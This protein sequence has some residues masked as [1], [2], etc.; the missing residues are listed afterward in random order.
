MDDFA[1]TTFVYRKYVDKTLKRM[2]MNK[3]L[4]RFRELLDRT[5]QRA[6]DALQIPIS[7]SMNGQS[8]KVRQ[9]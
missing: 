6:R 9:K 3:M 8:P 1:K 5:L 7:S 4:L 2:G